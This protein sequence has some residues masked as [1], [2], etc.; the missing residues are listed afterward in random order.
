[1]EKKT[2]VFDELEDRIALAGCAAFG[3]DLMVTFA[4]SGGLGEYHAGVTG[5]GQQGVIAALVHNFHDTLCDD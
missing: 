1:M 2:L 3:T 5:P 4:Q